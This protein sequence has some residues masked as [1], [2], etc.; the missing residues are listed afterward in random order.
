MI[1]LPASAV[2]SRAGSNLNEFEQGV[3][4]VF[5]RLAGMLGIP[6]SVGEIYGLLFAT[7]RPLA[8]PDIGEM[9]NLSKGSIS[10][11]LRLLRGIGAV[12]LIYIPGDRRDHF[13]PETELRALLSG[14]LREN[15]RPH[16]ESGLARI[17]ILDALCRRSDF[18]G[19]DERTQKTLRQRI[20]K[21]QAW[22]K[23]GRTVVP[24]ISKLVG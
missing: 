10:Q 17:K 21:L 13:V 14:F 12:K 5:V 24:I 18:S 3:I 7:A 8:F 2:D 22:H 9:L 1:Q 16:L 15:V 4:D 11:G 6:K 23:K 19:S 20:E